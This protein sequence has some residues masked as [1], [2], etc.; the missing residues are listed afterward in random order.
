LAAFAKLRAVLRG[1]PRHWEGRIPESEQ[2]VR[3]EDAALRHI[4]RFRQR[5]QSTK[6][7][8]GQLFGCVTDKWVIVSKA[9]G[10]SASDERGLFSFRS[11]PSVAQKAIQRLHERGLLYL[12]E[13][14]TH[15]ELIPLPSP[16]DLLAMQQLMK[17]SHLNT[18]AILLVILGLGHPDTDVGAWYVDETNLLRAI[19]SYGVRV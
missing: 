10:P 19:V 18:R 7:A 15:A 9:V 14:H 2:A 3:I 6:E 8:G 5:G 11:D 4:R 16:S 1:A 12:G 13:W 17:R